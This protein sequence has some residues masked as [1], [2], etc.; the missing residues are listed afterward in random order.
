MRGVHRLLGILILFCLVSIPAYADEGERHRPHH[1]TPDCA[2]VEQAAHGKHHHDRHHADKTCKDKK[3]VELTVILEGSGSGQ[4]SSDPAGIDCPT[5]CSEAYKKNTQI[6]LSAQPDTGSVFSGW[7]GDCSG[8]GDCSIKLKADTNVSANFTNIEP[9]PFSLVMP[10]VNEADMSEINDYFNAQYDTLPWGRIHDGLDIDPNDNLRPYQAACSGQVRKV[11]VFDNQ[12]TLIIDCNETYSLDYNFETQA[13]NT[14]QTQLANI[15]VSEGQQVAQGDVI[16]YLYS[17]ENPDKAHVH[18]TLFQN[19]VPIC[20]AP[21]F[22]QAAHDSILNLLAVVHTD[23][24]MCRSGNV[25][26]PP[27]ATPYVAEADMAEISAGYSSN[28]LSPWGYPN[29]GLTIV[30]QADL[31]PMQAACSGT[32]D[33]LTLQQDGI[34]GNWQVEVAVVCDDYVDDPDAGGYFIPLTTHYDFQTM[35]TDPTVGQAQLSNIMVPL[36][37]H[38]NQGD[39]IGYLKAVNPNANVLFELLQ[40]GQSAFQ[41]LGV[42]GMPLCPQAHFSPSAQDSVLNLLHVAWPGAQMCYQ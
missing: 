30:P 36:G 22:T 2:T 31:K 18:F 5:D 38:V 12:V 33:A 19:A 1:N 24:V 20:P 40:F 27:L 41:V 10:Y 4:V 14:G 11:Y 21:Y 26:P 6:V 25:F 23:G 37:Q 42:T 35:S 32:I 29:D 9:P 34:T 13:P 17:A 7:G 28:S 8:T 39:T 3:T 16:G 15:L